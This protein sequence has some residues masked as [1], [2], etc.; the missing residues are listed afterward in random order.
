MHDNVCPAY[1]CGIG[2]ALQ[3]FLPLPV[4]SDAVIFTGSRTALLLLSTKSTATSFS[5]EI[6]DICRTVVGDEWTSHIFG[7]YHCT[8]ESL[9]PRLLI[10]YQ[11]LLLKMKSPQH[12]SIDGWT[13]AVYFDVCCVCFILASALRLALTLQLGSTRMCL[14]LTPLIYIISD[15]TLSSETSFYSD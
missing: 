10:I 3:Y 9:L 7:G 5:R 1:V 13:Q 11:E 14:A 2:L 12:A 15:A 6:V 8:M 4:S